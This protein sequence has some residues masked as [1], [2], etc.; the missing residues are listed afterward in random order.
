M[1]FYYGRHQ[2][3]L[4]YFDGVLKPNTKL[5][6]AVRLLEGKIAG[7]ESITTDRNGEHKYTLFRFYFHA[8]LKVF[9]IHLELYVFF[10]IC[11]KF[12][13]SFVNGL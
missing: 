3:K 4:P 7:P 2:H 10:K 9:H 8:H 12:L 11:S 1:F 13:F 6:E 5:Q